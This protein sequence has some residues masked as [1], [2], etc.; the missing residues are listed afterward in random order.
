MVAGEEEFQKTS[1]WFISSLL[2]GTDSSQLSLIIFF[3]TLTSRSSNGIEVTAA[4]HK[5]CWLSYLGCNSMCLNPRQ[6]LCRES[7]LS[8][9]LGEGRVKDQRLGVICISKTKEQGREVTVLGS[10]LRYS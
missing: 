5:A 10:V 9:Y 7:K 8:S 6:V 4:A 2:D 3:T 1:G